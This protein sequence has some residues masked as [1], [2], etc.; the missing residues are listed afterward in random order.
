MEEGNHCRPHC[1]L[2]QSRDSM[3]SR[4]HGTVIG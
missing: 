1:R 2:A 3:I 4:K